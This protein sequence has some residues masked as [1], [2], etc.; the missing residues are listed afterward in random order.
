[1]SL[2]TIG[3]LLPLSHRGHHDNQGSDFYDKKLVEY[4]KRYVKK[5]TEIY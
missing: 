1:M 2:A 5:T 4:V 3:E